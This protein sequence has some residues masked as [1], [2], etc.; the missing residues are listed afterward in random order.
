MLRDSLLPQPFSLPEGVSQSTVCARS[1]SRSPGPIPDPLNPVLG[2]A[3]HM[4]FE[5]SEN[6]PL[7]GKGKRPGDDWAG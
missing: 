3:L 1:L 6:C 5:K 4:E 7:Q 2:A